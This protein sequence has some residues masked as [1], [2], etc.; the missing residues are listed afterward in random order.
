MARTPA[1]KAGKYEQLVDLFQ[2]YDDKGNLA[3]SYAKGDI[4]SLNAEQAERLT[5][6]D[7][8]A[9]AEPG[10]LAQAEADRLQAAADVAKANAD[11]AKRRAA[12]AAKATGAPGKPT[13]TS[14]PP[15]GNASLEDWHGYA[16]T[17]EGVTEADLEGLSRDD[18]R[19]RYA[20]KS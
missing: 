9:F 18:L 5:T 1:A 12:A 14:E 20:P 11:D 17:Q 3:A 7:T 15:A 13:G 4:V 19:E 10:S 2:E 6:G 8:P 16:L